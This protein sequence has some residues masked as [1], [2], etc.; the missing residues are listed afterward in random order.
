MVKHAHL[1]RIDAP[2]SYATDIHDQLFAILFQKPSPAINTARKAL[3]EI[4]R[5]CHAEV[6][7]LPIR[8]LRGVVESTKKSLAKLEAEE[9]DEAATEP[10]RSRLASFGRDLAEAPA[11][12]AALKDRIEYYHAEKSAAK[13]ALDQE[14]EAHRA[15][16]VLYTRKLEEEAQRLLAIAWSARWE[17]DP[18]TKGSPFIQ[19]PFTEAM[20]SGCDNVHRAMPPAFAASY[21]LIRSTDRWLEDFQP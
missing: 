17:V 14:L 8:E 21:E 18:K 15:R 13:A 20:K 11:K 19:R 10:L 12:L 2:R 3:E 4:H 7:T 16:V 9:A 6:N 1:S 5:S